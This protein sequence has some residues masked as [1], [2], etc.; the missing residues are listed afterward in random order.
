MI[1]SNA[2]G[3]VSVTVLDNENENAFSIIEVSALMCVVPIASVAIRVPFTYLLT[4]LLLERVFS[5]S[6]KRDGRSL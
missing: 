5:N 2:V 6:A 3:L 1:T 4:Y